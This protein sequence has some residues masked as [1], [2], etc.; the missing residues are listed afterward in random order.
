MKKILILLGAL[1]LTWL[2]DVA[3][4]NEKLELA[5]KIVMG[6]GI[7]DVDANVNSMTQMM[8]TRQPEL[9]EYRS[10]IHK[11]LSEV[12]KS[13]EYAKSVGE[14]YAD[15]FTLDELKEFEKLKQNPVMVKW[16]KSMPVI[17]P[18]IVAVMRNTL[19]PVMR[20]LSQEIHQLQNKKTH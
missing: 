11:H 2:S 16:L 1:I 12:F 9:A 8:I 4:E 7:V 20:D 17:M 3:D 13:D 6:G 18:E 15:H 5:T 19:V 14:V 10:L